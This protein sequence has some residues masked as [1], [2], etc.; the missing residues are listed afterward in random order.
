M[1]QINRTNDKT[2]SLNK[3]TIDNLIS[4]KCEQSLSFGPYLRAEG[5]T[6]IGR[7]L[8]KQPNKLWTRYPFRLL[9]ETKAIIIFCRVI[10]IPKVGASVW[11]SIGASVGGMCRWLWRWERASKGTWLSTRSWFYYVSVIY[12]MITVHCWFC[13]DS[14]LYGKRTRLV[15]ETEYGIVLS[16]AVYE[17]S[18]TQCESTHTRSHVCPHI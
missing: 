15:Y 10:L 11:T 2:T 14:I 5:T 4:K 17:I 6:V 9:R 13:I 8:V 18:L 7:I 3:L 16:L 12:E 1:S